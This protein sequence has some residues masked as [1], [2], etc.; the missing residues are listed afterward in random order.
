[1]ILVI[2]AYTQKGNGKRRSSLVG[3]ST[4]DQRKAYP[5]ISSIVKAGGHRGLAECQRLFKN[6]VW[7]CT[8]DDKLVFKELP[9]FFKTTLPYATR[10][11]AFL[12]AISNAA[13][14]HEITQQCRE[15]K[16]PGCRC[17][18]LK[19]R[20]PNNGNGDWQWGGCSDNIWFGENMTRSFI[21]SLEQDDGA[22]KV[23]NLHNNDFGRKV[24][25]FKVKRE[26]KCHGVTGSCNF[27]T[28]WKSLA[29]FSVVGAELKRRYRQAA[30]VTL[31]DDVLQDEDNKPVSRKDRKLVFLDPSP[32]YCVRNS[33]AG[34]LGLLGRACRS[35]DVTTSKCRS[36][37]NS[38]SLGHKTVELKKDVKCRCK[39]VWCCSVEC[40][41]CTKEYSVTTCTRR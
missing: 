24:V 1:M 20:Q 41:T 25:K 7:N 11:T 13:I 38:C 17:V 34:S 16:I 26:C 21:D 28:C 15:N 2:L 3:P 30:K 6:E 8:L 37:C 33:T 9:I 40:E 31:V 32:D 22:R 5:L 12:H 19:N 27:K 10:E 39:F 29:P 4:T 23:V 14:T 36:L 18:E 35:D